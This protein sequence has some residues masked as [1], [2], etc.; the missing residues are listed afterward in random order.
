VPN[1]FFQRAEVGEFALERRDIGDVELHPLPPNL[2]R[3]C[4]VK[5]RVVAP[6]LA[7]V[8]V[9]AAR[10]PNVAVIPAIESA[11]PRA[12]NV[13]GSSGHPLPYAK[14]LIASASVPQP[15]RCA[16][17]PVWPNPEMRATIRSG[18]CLRRSSGPNPH[19]SSVPG[20]KFS[21]YGVEIERDGAFV[22]SNDLPR[23]ALTVFLVAP[24]AELVAGLRHLDFDDAGAVIGKQ[25]PTK[26]RCQHRRRFDHAYSG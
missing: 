5:S 20:R 11:K 26:R 12:G 13:G 2:V 7:A 9:C 6:L 19:F 4:V 3:E 22:A 15:A 10:I 8:L 25:H 16:F 21:T 23:Q 1:S 17:G 24:V 18:L 14:S